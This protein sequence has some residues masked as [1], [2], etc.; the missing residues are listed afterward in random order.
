MVLPYLNFDIFNHR[1]ITVLTVCS[2]TVMLE[3]VQWLIEPRKINDRTSNR[4]SVFHSETI[5][6]PCEAQT[7]VTFHFDNR[8][9]EMINWLYW[10]HWKFQ[11]N[12]TKSTVVPRRDRFGSRVHFVICVHPNRA[13]LHNPPDKGLIILDNL[14]IHLKRSKWLNFT[15]PESIL[16]DRLPFA[17]ITNQLLFT[18]IL[19][20]EIIQIIWLLWLSFHS[21]LNF[22]Q[23]EF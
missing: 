1:N 22:W 17:I 20:S 9:S 8:S 13:V 3:Q 19:N 14:K 6:D 16:P 2:K 7:V 4:T 11:K 5:F 15:K 23:N 18:S 10:S 21:I 12:L